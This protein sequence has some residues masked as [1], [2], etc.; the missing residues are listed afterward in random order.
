MFGVEKETVC[1]LLAETLSACRRD[2]AGPGGPFVY[3]M[4]IVGHS[5]ALPIG[6]AVDILTLSGEAADF[7]R[8]FYSAADAMAAGSGSPDSTGTLNANTK[9][10][11][12]RTS[13][14]PTTS[15]QRSFS[16]M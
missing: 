12:P 2:S 7:Q 10:T 1:P 16:R 4:G 14:K 6:E 9:K 3:G 8:T 13:P 11:A 15:F 5:S